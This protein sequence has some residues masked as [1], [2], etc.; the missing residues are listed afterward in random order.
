VPIQRINSGY[1]STDPDWLAGART[2]T[3]GHAR[4]KEQVV[5]RPRDVRIGPDRPVL[6]RHKRKWHGPVTE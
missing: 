2:V 1:C 5:T 6:L 3:S 4:A